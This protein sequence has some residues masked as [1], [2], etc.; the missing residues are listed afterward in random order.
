MNI[1]QFG[2]VE[3]RRQMDMKYFNSIINEIERIFNN[4]LCF[5]IRNALLMHN[6]LIPVVNK[7]EISKHKKQSR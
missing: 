3:R 5:G 1:P 4:M 7:N 2:E 6:S